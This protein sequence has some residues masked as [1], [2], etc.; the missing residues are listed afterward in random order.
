[1]GGGIIINDFASNSE[2]FAS[3]SI[4]SSLPGGALLLDKNLEIKLTNKKW[5][6]KMAELKPAFTSAGENKKF[7][8]FLVQIGCFSETVKNVKKKLISIIEQ[9]EQ[10][11]KEAV[12]FP[13]GNKTKIFEFT[14]SKY[15]DGVL[16]LTEDITIQA[17]RKKEFEMLKF[18][19]D[20]ADIMVMRVTPAGEILYANEQLSKKLNY[21]PEEMVGLN[22]RKIL[23]EDEFIDRQKFWH[24]IKENNSISYERKFVSKEGRV[25]S[26]SI[27]SQFFEYGEEEYEFVFAQDI[28]AQ[29]EM[30][31]ELR[32]REQQ[33]R[34]IFN[35]APVGMEVKDSKGIIIDVNDRLCELTGYDKEELVGES[36]FDIIVPKEFEDKAREDFNKIL[37]GENLE[38][39]LPSRKKSGEYYFVN[40][41][42]TRIQLPGGEYGIISMRLDVTDRLEAEKELR[43][44]KERFRSLAETSPFGL[45]VYRDKFIYVNQALVEMTGYSKEEILAMNFWELV[46]PEHQ[47]LVK[48]RGYARLKGKK[49]IS[50][51]EFKLQHK[52]GK[53]LWILFSGTRIDYRGGPA[54]L[55]TVINIS[56]RKKAEDKL[57]YL[58]YHDSL[59]S[60]YNRT[61]VEE[62][63]A[64]LN[65]ERQHPLSIIYCDVNGLKIVNDTYGHKTGDELLEEV[66][67]IL[68]SAI[69]DEDL[70]AR[71]AGDEFVI[72]L[73]QTDSALAQKIANR[74][75]E[76][77]QRAN[78][79][80][81]PISL[82][83]G[84]ATKKTVEEKFQEVLSRA[85]KKMYENKLT[86]ANS[87]E[88]K[89]VQ[90]MMNT[91]GAKSAET[92]E[93]AMRMTHLAHQLGDKINLSNEQ[94]N[95]LSLLATLHDIGKTTISEKI[96]TK[97]GDLSEEEWQIIKEH[98]ERGYKIASATEEFAPIAKAILHHH[99]KW[100]GSGYPAGLK[101]R[102]IPLLSRIIAIVDAFDVMTSGR[103]YKKPM[104]EEE[105]L[106]EI[107]VCSGDQFD[108]ELAEEF[109]EM[110][111]G[112]KS[113]NISLDVN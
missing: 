56:E 18:S 49:P 44:E 22:V 13:A 36:L 89:L 78:F 51:Y 95:K 8:K 45:C 60:L 111:V 11:L 46:A 4:F 16:I 69:R 81:I 3:Q 101:G 25:F 41:K 63:M 99:E 42:D 61:F 64:R 23:A 30:E 104:S 71:W 17:E 66:A 5:K 54:G 48:K 98:P 90:N 83:I 87:A 43:E 24:K 14:F 77:C 106:Q 28:T 76:A 53:K 94:L 74:I 79:K 67:R 58:S 7:S 112:Q 100:D 26:V 62:E 108:P 40:L 88:N 19:V 84:I 105:A 102:E 110:I 21:P 109:V 50:N 31:E 91:L 68:N 20:N 37:A 6:E 97:P 12:A 27:V 1:M 55:G 65:T 32:V 92:K 59:T 75:E 10:E 2:E 113:K 38:Q 47:A 15:K 57:R 33:Y 93:H 96:L 72:L 9:R 86:K 34:K 107:E 35:T 85:D 73:P 29:K 52:D 103:P 80:D 39:L 70:L 82:G